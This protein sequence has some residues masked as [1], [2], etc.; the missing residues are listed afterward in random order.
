MK[1]KLRWN[2]A[3]WEWFVLNPKTDA[4]IYELPDCQNFR[5]LFPRLNKEADNIYEVQA[6]KIG[7]I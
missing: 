3:R 1:V 6:T 2:P 4:N 5:D 7:E